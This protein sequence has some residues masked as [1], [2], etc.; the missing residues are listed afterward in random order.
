MPLKDKEKFRAYQRDYARKR[1]H[2]G[3]EWRAKSLERNRRWKAAQPKSSRRL[4][5]FYGIEIAPGTKCLYCERP[6]KHL[7]LCQR[8]YNRWYQGVQMEKPKQDRQFNR[9]E[10]AWAAGLWD[11]EGS[12]SKAPRLMADGSTKFY[13][14]MQMGQVDRRNLERFH[15]AIGGIGKVYGPVR[16]PTQPRYDWRASSFEDC[17]AVIAIL[18]KW[19]SP[20]KRD[21]AMEAMRAYQSSV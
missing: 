2:D 5:S 10:V 12:T 15:K 7:A 16:T 17:Q 8:H 13:F 20:A 14:K 1:Y 3:S 6:S 21:Q 9:E 4:S 19:L 11:G 18:W